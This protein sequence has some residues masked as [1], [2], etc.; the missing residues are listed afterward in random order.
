MALS[1]GFDLGLIT[2]TYSSEQFSEAFNKIT[3]DGVA[4]RLNAFAISPAGGLVVN[5]E[6]GYAF[7][8]GRWAKLDSAIQLTF[9]HSNISTDRYDA[10]AIRIDYGK[11]LSVIDIIENVNP[12]SFE[13][14]TGVL[15]LYV[16]RIRRGSASITTDD[17]TDVRQ[18]LKP[19]S[20][21]GIEKL[22]E[23]YRMFPDGLDDFLYRLY[24]AVDD[25]AKNNSAAVERATIFTRTNTEDA[26][27]A[28]T[29]SANEIVKKADD[30]FGEINDAS[31]AK[32][33]DM[34]F[35]AL[36]P[37]VGNIWLLCDGSEISAN[38]F[39]ELVNLI[40]DTRPN[41]SPTDARINAWICAGDN[42][43]EFYFI[44]DDN[45]NLNVESDNDEALPFYMDANGNLIYTGE[46]TDRFYLDT[47][48]GILYD[49]KIGA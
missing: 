1:Y 32:L 8:S 39:S 3:G 10:I 28:A 40:G 6:S 46:E 44:I 38:R 45:G 47:E 29:D 19:L 23:A 36:K 13:E 17:I 12:D 30:I 22:I 4:N 2:D 7:V 20:E 41:I 16:I 21:M 26:I 33:G 25:G 5:V 31:P 11:R 14:I 49:R 9:A 42:A 15:Y 27:N 48:T 43:L 35:A 24:D 34:T 18:M 37:T